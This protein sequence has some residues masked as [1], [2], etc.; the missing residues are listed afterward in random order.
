MQHE[1]HCRQLKAMGMVYYLYRIRKRDRK[2]RLLPELFCPQ[3]VEQSVR[4]TGM[5]AVHEFSLSYTPIKEI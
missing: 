4:I 1:P 3:P 2:T 5:R